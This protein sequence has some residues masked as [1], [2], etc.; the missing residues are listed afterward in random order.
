[1]NFISFMHCRQTHS[2]KMKFSWLQTSKESFLVR[3]G[4]HYISFSE[5]DFRH[6]KCWNLETKGENL[7]FSVNITSYYLTRS[8][9]TQSNLNTSA[10]HIQIF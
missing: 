1:M 8:P 3:F 2:T 6:L 10:V 5:D 9:E 7:T 4:S